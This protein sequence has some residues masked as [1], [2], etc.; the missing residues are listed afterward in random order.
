MIQKLTREGGG[1]AVGEEAADED[2]TRARLLAATVEDH[3]LLDP[4]LGP[5]RLL[6]RLF[7]EEE[8]RVF[9]AL[10][11]GA[12]CSCSRAGVEGLLARFSPEDLA[13]MVVDDAVTVTCEFCNRKYHFGSD[14]LPHAG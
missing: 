4:T 9:R 1:G 14:A 6:F 5:E 10:E 3:E 2:W 7:H 8:V 12:Y 13:D 11:L